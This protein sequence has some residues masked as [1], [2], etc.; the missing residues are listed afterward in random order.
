MDFVWYPYVDHRVMG[1]VP[2]RVSA[3][4]VCSCDV[5][6]IQLFFDGFLVAFSQICVPLQSLLQSV[7]LNF[8]HEVVV[9]ECDVFLPWKSNLVSITNVFYGIIED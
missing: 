4:G 3:T 2:D 5:V 7:P 1:K 8:G 9:R 6:F